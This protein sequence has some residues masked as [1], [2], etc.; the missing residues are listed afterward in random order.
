MAFLSYFDHIVA[1]NRTKK[2][3]VM[4]IL[5]VFLV[6]LPALNEGGSFGGLSQ[7]GMAGTNLEACINNNI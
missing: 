5:M 4:V 1:C 2:T 6:F 3:D 7:K